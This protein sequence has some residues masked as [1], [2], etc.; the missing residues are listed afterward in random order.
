M[1][2]GLVES[3]EQRL[4]GDVTETLKS[5]EDFNRLKW[6]LVGKFSETDR[7]RN[8]QIAYNKAH[9][10]T[11][12][13]VMKRIKDL[14]DG[15]YDADEGKKQLGSGIVALV[16]TSEDGK[17]FT[18][19]RGGEGKPQRED[20]KVDSIDV[21]ADSFYEYL[22]DSWEMFG[23]AD[24]FSDFFHA[25][26]GGGAGVTLSWGTASLAVDLARLTPPP[27]EAI[28]RSPS[29]LAAVPSAS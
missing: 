8:K 1:A 11:P 9:S 14:I 28:R 27:P 15:V 23:D 25:F 13:G 17:T 22:W 3:L 4:P 18:R 24:P 19:Y 5:G 16:A 21:Y 6:D 20:L 26:F 2:R 7:R 10:I 12:I 29:Q